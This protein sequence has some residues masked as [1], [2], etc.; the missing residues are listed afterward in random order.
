[1]LNIGKPFIDCFTQ[2][3]VCKHTEVE[4]YEKTIYEGVRICGACIT[5]GT[6]FC[7]C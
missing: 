4:K 2:V 1:M 7:N 3:H 6:I 5:A